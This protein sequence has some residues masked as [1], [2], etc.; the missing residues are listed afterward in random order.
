MSRKLQAR[1]QGCS[2]M[3]VRLLGLAIAGA[4]LLGV[5][6]HA[7]IRLLASRGRKRG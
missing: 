6:G 3:R 4:T 1:S 2:A 7:G 5:L